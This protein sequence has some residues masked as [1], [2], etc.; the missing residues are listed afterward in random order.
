MTGGAPPQWTIV[1]GAAAERD[2]AVILTWSAEQF[3]EGQARSYLSRMT[4]LLAALAHDP[5]R[6]ASKAREELAPG[7]RSLHLH[8]IGLR[9]RHLALYRC[10]DRQVQI[11]RLLH[12]SMEVSRHLPPGDDDA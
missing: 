6:P 1:L 8:A 2:F 12:D 10:V 5:Y 9:G 11:I 4:D 7:L 3:G